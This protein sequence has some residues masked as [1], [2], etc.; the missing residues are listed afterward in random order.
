MEARLRRA[1]YFGSVQAT[2]SGDIS[3][4]PGRRQT[5]PCTEAKLR[6]KKEGGFESTIFY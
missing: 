4:P 2:Y 3:G 1:F 6:A 5:T